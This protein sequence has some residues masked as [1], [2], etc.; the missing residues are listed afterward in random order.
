[1]FGKSVN[2]KI[3]GEVDEDVYVAALERERDWIN[4]R[5][6]AIRSDVWNDDTPHDSAIC[7][8]YYALNARS[9]AILSQ[10]AAPDEESLWTSDEVSAALVEEDLVKARD[11]LYRAEKNIYHRQQFVENGTATDYTVRELRM[12]ESVVEDRKAEVYRLEN[13]LIDNPASGWIPF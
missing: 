5:L 12:W 7:N 8:E 13:L 1:M 4:R 9:D 10:I 3:Q 6:D 11:R 2:D